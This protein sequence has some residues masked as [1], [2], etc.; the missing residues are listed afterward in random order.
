[1]QETIGRA[2]ALFSKEGRVYAIHGKGAEGS[3]VRGVGIS[4]EWAGIGVERP[5]THDRGV[6]RVQAI[7][8]HDARSRQCTA[9]AYAS[10]IAAGNGPFTLTASY[11]KNAGKLAKV[12]VELAGARLANL[13]NTELQ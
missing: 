12:R 8:A 9:E 3:G 4:V 7:D 5:R 1:M 11:K 10:P 6:Y 2:N 13:L